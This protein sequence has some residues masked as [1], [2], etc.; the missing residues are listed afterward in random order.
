MNDQVSCN[1]GY[2]ALRYFIQRDVATAATVLAKP[3]A[4][5]TD[6]TTIG[7]LV[8]SLEERREIPRL[9]TP[10]WIALSDVVSAIAG[11]A[12]LRAAA[13]EKRIDEL[14]TNTYTHWDPIKILQESYPAPVKQ[15]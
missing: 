6:G 14:A 4:G 8:D 15:G 7:Q 9:G 2:A 5:S 3:L 12:Q 1:L 13:Y 11:S 10:D